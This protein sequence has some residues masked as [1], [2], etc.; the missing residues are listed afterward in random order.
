MPDTD[1]DP[2]DFERFTGFQDPTTTPVPDL[3]F[4]RIMPHLNESELKVMLY[5]IRRTYGFKR[6]VDT[7]S[8][9]QLATGITKRDGTILDYGTGLSRSTVKRA[10]RSLKAKNL[11]IAVRNTDPVRGNRPTAYA[12]NREHTPRVTNGPRVGP[13]MNLG[14]GSPENPPWAHQRAPQET[15]VQETGEQETD[16]SNIRKEST[17]ETP[18]GTGDDYDDPDRQTIGFLIEGLARTLGDQAPLKS[19]STRAYRLFSASTAELEDYI[20]LMHEARAITQE[21]TAA[22]TSEGE[23]ATAGGHRKTKMAYFFAVLENRLHER[24]LRE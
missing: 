20:A 8:L 15:G 23:D 2:F 13:T 7:I 24:R 19:S 5:I 17:A 11:I 1:D 18:N 22:I 12:L 9:N 3:L 16:L 14:L 10:V 6:R 4:D 21:R